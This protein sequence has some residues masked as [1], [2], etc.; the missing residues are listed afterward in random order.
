MELGHDPPHDSTGVVEETC[1]LVGAQLFSQGKTRLSR[2]EKRKARQ[3][4][5]WSKGE[6]QKGVC[7]LVPRA[8]E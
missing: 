2:G 4:L 3:P 1:Q 7:C 6:P 8:I 5:M